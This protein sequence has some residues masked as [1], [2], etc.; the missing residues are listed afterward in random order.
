MSLFQFWFPHGVCLEVILLG[1]MVAKPTHLFLKVLES[2]KSDVMLLV[3]SVPGET[4]FLAWRWLSAPWI[5]VWQ[6]ESGYKPYYVPSL[7]PHGF[8]SCHTRLSCSMACGIFCSDTG[9]SRGEQWW[10]KA[11]LLVWCHQL[12]CV[13]APPTPNSYTEALTLNVT[14]FEDW[15]SEDN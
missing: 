6:R 15:I 9:Q 11:L 3:D 13:P 4:L 2:G 1:C 8:R 14:V 12:N 5:L 10:S 7:W